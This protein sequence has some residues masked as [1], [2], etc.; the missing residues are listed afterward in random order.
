[1]KKLLVVLLS[2]GLIV[3]LS[4]AAS[5]VDVKFSGGYYVAGVYDNNADL[6]ASDAAYSRAYFFQRVRLQPVF[7]IAE[8]LTLTVRIDALEKQWGNTNWRTGFAETT[9]SRPSAVVNTTTGVG[10]SR[11][12]ENI[13]FERAYVTFKTAIGQFDVGYQAAGAWGTV[14]ANSEV[15]KPRIK[16]TTQAGPMTLLAIYEKAFEADTSYTPGYVATLSNGKTDADSDNYYLAGIYSFKGGNAGLLYGFL[17]NDSQR[18]STT[19]PPRPYTS[20]IHLLE[21]YVKATFGPVYVEA[22]VDY[23]FGDAQKFDNVAGATDVKKDGWSAYLM[24]KANL[25]PA[26]FG[27]QVGW[28]AGDDNAADDTDHSGAGGGWDWNPALILMNDDLN[29]WA[30]G[31]GANSANSAKTNFLLYNTFVGFNV[32]PKL[33]V[34]AALTYAKKDK[35]TA[36]NVSDELGWEFDVTATYKLYDNLS[37]MVGAGYLWA[38]DYFKGTTNAPKEIGNDYMLMNKLTLSF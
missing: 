21:P 12:Q 20:K 38:G 23:F 17:N 8:G 18:V 24:V 5:A 10:T 11:A 26:Y 9:N 1:M 28:A 31:L 6:Q 4:T 29:T 22:E 36:A 25:G 16:F 19:V 15:T 30:G 37:Y 3:A 14:F 13:E 27:G 33:N 34:E 35:I 32:T 7:Q 2:L